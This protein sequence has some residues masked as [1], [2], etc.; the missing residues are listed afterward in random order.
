MGIGL[1]ALIV[2]SVSLNALAQ[3]ALRKAMLVAGTLPPIGEPI[4]LGM[5]LITNVWL[6]A[7]MVCY[8]LSIGLWLAVLAK[9]E[10]SAAYPMLSIGYVIAAVI[11]LTFLGEAVSAGRWAG[12]AMICAGVFVVARTV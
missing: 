3:I 12:I 10:V 11:G 2:V 7:G 4:A 5:A 6:W 9:V 8:A 1:F